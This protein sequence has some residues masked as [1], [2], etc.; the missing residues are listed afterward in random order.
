MLQ[1]LSSPISGEGN[2]LKRMKKTKE[3]SKK[4]KV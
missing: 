3:K 1:V 2:R 4:I